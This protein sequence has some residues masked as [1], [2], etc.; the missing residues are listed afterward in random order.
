MKSF[1][2]VALIVLAAVLQISN[3]F[4]V[5]PSS[6]L[7]VR[8]QSHSGMQMLFGGG[9]A[10]KKAAG[11]IVVK[12]QQ[13]TG[14]KETELTLA[15]KTNLRK[16]LMDNKIDIYPLQGKIYN[17]G[18]GGSC[19]TCAVNVKAGAQNCSP[20][21]PGEKKLLDKNKR[22]ASYRLSCCTMVSGP[23]TVQTKP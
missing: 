8:R 6:S 22:P 5:A 18:G 7:N 17:C 2:F 1:L 13:K 16:A 23:V 10:K 20:K 4:V 12:V 11:G 9:G 3:G 21:G 19:G 15:G 14:F